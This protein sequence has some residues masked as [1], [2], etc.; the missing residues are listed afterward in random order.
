[1]LTNEACD[2]VCAG[3]AFLMEEEAL[4]DRL[5]HSP[6]SDPRGGLNESCSVRGLYVHTLHMRR[7]EF[8]VDV[9]KYSAS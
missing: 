4:P 2:V 9:M 8:Q 1:M 6:A 5:D 7:T 3:E